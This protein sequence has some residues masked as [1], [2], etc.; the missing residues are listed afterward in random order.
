MY[1]VLDTCHSVYWKTGASCGG[2]GSA[3]PSGAPEY[4]PCFT[5]V[6]VAWSVVFCI[7]FC[8]LLFVLLS[9]FVW[10]LN[11]LSFFYL[12]LLITHL[13]YSN[14]SYHIPL[15]RVHLPS[16][17]NRYLLATGIYNI[18]RYAGS[19][20]MIVATPTMPSP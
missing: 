11:C 16:S 6:R 5:A 7:V 20:P 3:Y 1:V 19:Y 4:T 9:F 8:W 10:P 12:R 15:Y 14:L 2:A 17:W 13:V 18:G